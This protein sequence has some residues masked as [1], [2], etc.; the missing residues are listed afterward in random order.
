MFSTT[1]FFSSYLDSFG[2]AAANI[3]V[4]EF[5]Y[6]T[7]PAFAI[8]IVYCSIASCKIDLVNNKYIYK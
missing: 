8:E 3:A 6:A 4:L 5:N 7:I 2:L 1:D